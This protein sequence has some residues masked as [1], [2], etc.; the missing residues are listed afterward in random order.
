M[1]GGARDEAQRRPGTLLTHLSP[2]HFLLAPHLLQYVDIVIEYL[3][4]YQGTLEITDSLGTSLVTA[5]QAS[6]GWVAPMRVYNFP[7]KIKWDGTSDNYSNFY[8]RLGYNTIRYNPNTK[9]LGFKPSIRFDPPYDDMVLN[10]KNDTDAVVFLH[11]SHAK[12]VSPSIQVGDDLMMSPYLRYEYVIKAE[13]SDS[14]RRNVPPTLICTSLNLPD[15]GD[16]VTVHDGPSD[17]YPILTA[18]QGTECPTKWITG[19][20]IAMT[21]VLRTNEANHQGSYELSYYADGEGPRCNNQEPL[22]L[23]G[24]SSIFS[25]GTNSEME[26]WRTSYCTYHVKPRGYENGNVTMTFNRIGIKASASVRVWEGFEEVED[27]LLWY[28]D[29]CGLVAPMQLESR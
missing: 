14:K 2:A 8:I 7:V 5:A 18:L 16:N 24:P 29:G 26:M 25:D 6:T 11:Q 4:V 22:L 17:L 9:G 28:C 19:T 13:P 15:L 20:D 3:P 1:R 21:L 27:K 10:Y 23:E 12:I